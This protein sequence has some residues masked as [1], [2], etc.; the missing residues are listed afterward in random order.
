VGGFETKFFL[1]EVIKQEELSLD[2]TEDA[3]TFLVKQSSFPSFRNVVDKL[4]V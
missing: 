2:N 1:I 3:V 4:L